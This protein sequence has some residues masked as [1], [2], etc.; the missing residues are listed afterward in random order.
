[1]SFIRHVGEPPENENK[2]PSDLG[3]DHP[4]TLPSGKLG[5]VCCSL[6]ITFG[7]P[8]TYSHTHILTSAVMYAHARNPYVNLTRPPTEPTLHGSVTVPLFSLPSSPLRPASRH[9]KSSNLSGVEVRIGLLLGANS[10]LCLVRT[11]E[12]GIEK[13]MVKASLYKCTS[14]HCS[15]NRNKT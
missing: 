11:R 10:T 14:P 8:C 1:M 9:S 15:R 5:S 12:W 4:T 2:S 3:P 7:I 13:E 6:L